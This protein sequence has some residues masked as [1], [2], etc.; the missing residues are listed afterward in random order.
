MEK[1][2]AKLER[3]LKE[4][5]AFDPNLVDDFW[6]HGESLA[7]RV[8][9]TLE[10][11]FGAESAQ[12]KRAKCHVHF[13]SVNSVSLTGRSIPHQEKVDAFSEGL[14]RAFSLLQTE[15]DILQEKLADAP[16]FAEAVPSVSTQ[17]Q[18]SDDEVFIVHGHDEAPKQEVARFIEACGL[19]A[20]ILHELDNR[21]NTIIEKLE[22]H[23]AK[24]GFAVVLPTPDDVGGPQGRRPETACPSER[25]CRTILLCRQNWAGARSRFEEGRSRNPLGLRRRGSRRDGQPRRLEAGSR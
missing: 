16:T 18:F 13:F 10:E 23:T 24:I 2:I 19:K 20:K 3:R 6:A 5:Q 12:Y 1:G 9:S 15:L 17:T 11:I 21:G 7:T 22:R 4:I 25:H 14:R 8:N